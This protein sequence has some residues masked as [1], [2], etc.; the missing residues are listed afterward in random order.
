MHSSPLSFGIVA[1]LAGTASAFW[2]MSCPGD[3]LNERADPIVSPGQVSSHVH[4]IAGGNGFNFSMD[5]EDTQASICS[6]CTVKEDLSNYWTPKFYFHAKNGS[7]IDVPNAGL[8]VYYEQR[9]SAGETTL[10]AFPEGFRMVAGDPFK[11]N[12][13]GDL[14]AQAIQF[15]C[16]DYND[17]TPQ[18]NN[19]PNKNCPDGLRAQVYFPS[20]WDGVNLDS[21]DHKSHMSYPINNTFDNGN[22][23]PSHPVR[24]IS[25]FYE[26]LYSVNDFADQWYGDSQPFVFANGDPTG[27][28]FHG[29][30]ING[31]NV[32]V[33]QKAIETCTDSTGGVIEDTCLVLTQFTADECKACQL[34]PRINETVTGT[35]EKLPGCNELTYGPEPA[36]PQSCDDTATI[37]SSKKYY[38]D[39][40]SDGWA[41]VGCGSDDY[42]NRTFAALNTYSADNMTIAFCVEYCESNG[43]TWAGTEYSSQCYCDNNAPPADRA[44]VPGLI[45][46]CDMMCTGDE[47]QYCGGSNAIS[48]YQ[49]CGSDSCY[50]AAE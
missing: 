30:F 6:S 44:P 5:Y 27:Y 2:R 20:C 13:T 40:T 33:L 18:T 38:T 4:R 28:G 15:A 50:N 19:L 16:L 26:F 41:Y 35:L 32:T 11:R 37:G 29:D 39:V 25:L 3:V 31:W 34:A 36:T 7:Y 45:G 22:C 10:Q 21:P 43:Y 17:A 24:L 14:A 47:T 23:P 9:Y 49:K 46:E 48:I 8:F 42:F 1:T 12:Y